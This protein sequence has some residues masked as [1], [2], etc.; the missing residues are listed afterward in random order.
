MGRFSVHF[1]LTFKFTQVK[2]KKAGMPHRLNFPS[3]K[4][5]SSLKNA[6]G[7]LALS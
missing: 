2:I 4:K 3:L 1:S 5:L 6:I 7:K